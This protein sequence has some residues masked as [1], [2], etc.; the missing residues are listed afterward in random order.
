MEELSRKLEKKGQKGRAEPEAAKILEALKQRIE[1]ARACRRAGAN[2]MIVE[3]QEWRR[4]PR[5]PA[6]AIEALVAL[7]VSRPSRF[8]VS[9][10]ITPEG[11]KM[12]CPPLV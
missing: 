7:L 12:R 8:H 3:V 10:P 5:A 9:V 11:Q 2:E 4:P 1:M 6:A